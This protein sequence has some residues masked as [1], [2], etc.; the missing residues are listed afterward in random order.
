MQNLRG[1][2]L[3]WLNFAFEDDEGQFDSVGYDA[4]MDLTENLLPA[5]CA[6]TEEN[7][8]TLS[9]IDKYTHLPFLACPSLSSFFNL[10]M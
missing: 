2:P 4:M 10:Q 9:R 5:D 6:V 8:V 1:L 7:S 3:K